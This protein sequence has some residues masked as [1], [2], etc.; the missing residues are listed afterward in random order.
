MVDTLLTADA[1]AI[2][3]DRMADA[4]ILASDD[5]DMYPALFS[6]A[7]SDVRVL[8]LRRNGVIDP[9]YDGLF[10]MRGITLHTW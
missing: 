10:E 7:T 5:S 1:I 9:Y 3:R 2:A 8:G 6:A 4:L